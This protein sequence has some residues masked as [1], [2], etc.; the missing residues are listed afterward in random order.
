MLALPS[1][2]KVPMKSRF[3][4]TGAAGYIAPRHLKAI[5]DTGNSLVAILDPHDSVGIVDKY[6]PN[7]RYFSEPERFDRHLEKL[8][9]KGNNKEVHWMTICSPN[10]LHDAH[11]RMALR[12][13]AN[14]ICEKPIVL[15]PWNLEA[16]Q[17]LEKETK[18]RVYCMMQLRNHPSIV[19]LRNQELSSSSST[20]KDI[21]LTY[22]APRGAWYQSSWKGNLERA[23]GLASNIGVHFLDMLI[24]IYGSVKASIV[25]LNQPN[26]MAGYLELERARVKWF[27]SID[28]NDLK[29]VSNSDT[30]TYRS[31]TIEG[32]ELNFSSGFT[33]LHT[34]TYKKILNGNGA[35]LEDCKETVVLLHQIRNSEIAGITT[36]DSHEI[37]KLEVK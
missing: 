19:E 10:Y 32:K 9:R 16:L 27:L 34:D 25:Q 23:G 7:A 35:T 17:D 22:I 21:C 24:W 8:R 31:I 3:A 5:A 2:R 6:F 26:K 36:S 4:L 13:G 33:E 12:L 1:Q 15:N 20:Q 11:I 30:G 14:V 28:D 29:Y 37:A 18:S